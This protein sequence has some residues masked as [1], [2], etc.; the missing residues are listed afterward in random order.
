MPGVVKRRTR[1]SSGGGPPLQP[2]LITSQAV[3]AD[4]TLPASKRVKKSTTVDPDLENVLADK[5]LLVECLT[6]A[7]MVVKVKEEQNVLKEDQAI[8]LK[9]FNKDIST[10]LDYPDNIENL[11]ST[12]SNWL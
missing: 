12:L 11:F 7:G 8:F 2:Q 5:S 9:K 10:A 6:K 4:V 1:N 3:S